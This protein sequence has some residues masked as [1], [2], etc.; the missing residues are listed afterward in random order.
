VNSN[1][2][3]PNDIEMMNIEGHVV[4]ELGFI[5]FPVLG[6]ISVK[7]KTTKQIETMLKETSE[8]GAMGKGGEIFVFE[9][10]NSINIFDLA[11]KM[12]QFSGLHYPE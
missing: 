4:S 10:G 11:L 3:R 7:G 12:I 2:T 9:M 8:A 6:E 1:A 5:T